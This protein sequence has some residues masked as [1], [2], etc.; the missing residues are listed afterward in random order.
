MARKVFISFLGTNVYFPVYYVWGPEKR[1][2]T[3]YRTQ[4]VQEALVTELCREWGSDDCIMIFRT[5]QSNAKNWIDHNDRNGLRT[6]LKNIAGLQCQINP[7]INPEEDNYIIQTGF[8]E[9]D[10]W[11]IFKC[12]FDKI[13]LED[14]I[15]FDVTHA[16]R[17]I[18]MFTT[19]LFNYA[20]FLKHSKVKGVYYGAF[21][22][23]GSFS[24]V[25][26]MPEERLDVPI[27]DLTNIVRLQEINT[28]AASFRDFG[29][30][31]AFSSILYNTGVENLDATRNAISTALK[32]L[33]FYIQTSRIDDICRGE[34]MAV[35]ATGIEQFCNNPS[36]N[37][38]QRTLMLKIY[39][40]L[41]T[42]GFEPA[43]RYENI[44]AAIKW[45]ID[46]N[47]IQQAY[48]MAKEYLISTAYDIL[49]DLNLRTRFIEERM[50][51]GR[52]TTYKIRE[53]LNGIMCA[54]KAFDGQNYSFSGE[55][56]MSSVVAN[57][58]LNNKP[59]FFNDITDP[60]KSLT[61]RRNDLNHAGTNQG[62]LVYSTFTD[63][64]E[65]FRLYWQQ[66]LN[67]LNIFYETESI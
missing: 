41:L 19:A 25:Q 59:L 26:K 14:D 24:E 46:H 13:Q 35:L 21:E 18:P 29:V 12:I 37:E 52:N 64:Q 49:L 4:F 65:E 56:W 2:I 33:D 60:F 16:F 66:C 1:R 3:E 9:P 45:A 23:L 17:T 5:E 61:N 54:N 20:R 50:I 27:V 22:S 40:Q 8:S 47:M 10:L 48:T 28:A 53:A 15:Y 6:T 31:R 62:A 43:D 34:Y 38:A 7:E 57:E 55:P 67:V 32:N 36:T 44:E 11:Q 63:Y 30:M 51:I 42:Y 39:E 58:L